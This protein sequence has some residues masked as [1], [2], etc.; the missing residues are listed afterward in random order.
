MNSDTYQLLAGSFIPRPKHHQGRKHALIV[1]QIIPIIVALGEVAYELVHDLTQ[2]SFTHFFALLAASLIWMLLPTL[3]LWGIV[4]DNLLITGV[5]LLIQ[6]VVVLAYC[7]FAFAFLQYK[8]KDKELWKGGVFE[9]VELVL[10]G[11]FV[12]D[13]WLL[14]G[15]KRE[16]TRAHRL[17]E[18]A[19]ANDGEIDLE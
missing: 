4:R 17:Q 16:Q 9:C 8:I 3:N 18:M 2:S 19:E 10:Y 6:L 12:Y 11:L 7:V 13:L 1:L 5:F 15:M 14:R